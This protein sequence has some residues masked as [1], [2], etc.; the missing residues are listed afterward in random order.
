MGLQSVAVQTAQ[1]RLD[2]QVQWNARTDATQLQL[3]AQAPGAQGNIS[4]QISAEAG[5]GNSEWKVRDAKALLQWL[6]TLPWVGSQVQGL[7]AQGEAQA[8][9]RW[10]GG[11]QN[12]GSNMKVS[13]SL[14]S[15]RLDLQER[16]R[17][18]NGRPRAACATWTLPA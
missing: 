7:D 1:A 2:G 11:W 18:R 5:Q 13:A 10:D 4:G 9:I 14:Q 3:Q 8:T 17:L 12:R 15:A 6:Q 16:Y